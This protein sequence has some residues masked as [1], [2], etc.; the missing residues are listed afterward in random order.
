M[1]LSTEGVVLVTSPGTKS[2]YP[3]PPQSLKHSV[4]NP[5][6]APGIGNELPVEPEGSIPLS[7]DDAIEYQSILGFLFVY[8]FTLAC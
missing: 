3:R 5:V 7:K 8:Q 2:S 6:D 4:C 1:V